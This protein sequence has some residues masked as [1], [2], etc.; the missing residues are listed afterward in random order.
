MTS[1]T[2]RNRT[3]CVTGRT[4][5]T[6]HLIAVRRGKTPRPTAELDRVQNPH[7][8]SNLDLFQFYTNCS[9]RFTHKNPSEHKMEVS[10]T[11]SGTYII[12]DTPPLRPERAEIVA[13]Q[14][15]L[16]VSGRGSGG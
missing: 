3:Y 14:A 1:R 16:P 6:A 13:C 12:P 15:P 5:Q 8:L 11:A 7:I 4:K 9:T 10:L 2:G